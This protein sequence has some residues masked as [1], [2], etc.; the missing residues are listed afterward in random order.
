MSPSSS[1]CRAESV[2]VIAREVG[3]SYGTRNPC[4]P[5]Y[6]LVGVGGQARASTGE[7]DGG[8]S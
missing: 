6:P 2:R 1:A 4:Y 7:V 5:E 8:S 3:G